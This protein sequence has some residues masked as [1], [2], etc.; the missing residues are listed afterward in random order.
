MTT[1][2]AAHPHEKPHYPHWPLAALLF[3]FVFLLG[4]LSVH[5]PGTWIHVR[6]GGK[7]LAERAIPRTDPYSYT[8]AGRPWT[9]DSW[10]AD[11]LFHLVHIQFGPG[12]L[13]A[14]KS[15]AAATA[16]ALLLPLNPASPLIAAGVLGLGALASWAGLTE[17]P[18]I[19]DLLMLACLIRILRPRRGF[20]WSLVFQVAAVELLWANLHGATA[21]LGVW[22]AGLKVFKASL[23]TVRRERLSYLA[24]L[25]AAGLALLCNPHGLGVV[26]HLL[27]GTESSWTSWRPLS[28][29]FNL[30]SLFA[31]AGAAACWICLQQE[32]F[33]TINA[34]SLLALSFLFPDLRPLYVLAV[35]PV[36]SLALGHFMLPVADTP[37]RVGRWTA[38]MGALLA[39]HWFYVYV[40]LGRSRGYAAVSLE[41]ALNYLK[42]NGVAGRL[43]N[44]LESGA[45]LIGQGGRPVFV[46]D[47]SAL[48]GPAFMKDAAR[49]PSR[50]RQLSEVYRFDYALILNRRAGYPARALDEDP[51]WRLAYAD[52]AALVYIKRKGRSGWLVGNMPPRAAAP[53]RLWP[54]ALDVALSQPKRLPRI[55]EELDRWIVQSPDSVQALLWKAYALERLKL[56]SKAERLIALARG[57]PLFRDP[58]LMACL[59][60]VQ[61]ARGQRKAALGLYLRS[62]ML[63]RRLGDAALESSILSRLAPLYRRAGESAR[64]AVLEARARELSA[65][66]EE[67]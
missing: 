52:D 43:F 33:L 17:N 54:D 29:W 13:V 37:S 2:A 58:E 4:V 19:F 12:G 67:P 34:A 18:A 30:Y 62:A 51:D 40:P 48:Y 25:L 39:L 61:E 55:L 46:D 11:V 32:F 64:A 44:E 22:L 50:F 38:V 21:V 56:S 57:R 23:R 27:S 63:A 14:L 26:S 20:A 45:F 65:V 24:V 28:P 66:P 31:L 1:H 35:C 8:V 60:F 53:N 47:R 36:L 7:I 41:G 15:A 10:L 3:A 16:F 9:T 59:G 5:E 42:A 49:W 6:T